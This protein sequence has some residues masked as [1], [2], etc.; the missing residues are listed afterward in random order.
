MVQTKHYSHEEL[1]K[2]VFNSLFSTGLT[3]HSNKT[4]P[5]KESKLLSS[6]YMLWNVL[7][8]ENGEI[9]NS[10]AIFH[11]NFNS[12]SLNHSKIHPLILQPSTSF[13]I[14]HPPQH[15]TLF[16]PLRFLITHKTSIQST[17]LCSEPR[18]NNP[19]HETSRFC[20]F[21]FF[22]NFSNSYLKLGLAFTQHSLPQGLLQ[23]CAEQLLIV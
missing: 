3:A 1:Q 22:T 16:I 18:T 8:L 9:H 14:A 6:Q 19:P 4:L 12:V 5:Q 10:N 17:Y 11:Q 7:E 13:W 15:R 2:H 23:R 20:K 21:K